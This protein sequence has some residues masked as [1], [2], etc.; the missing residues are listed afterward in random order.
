MSDNPPSSVCVNKNIVL[1]KFMAFTQG[2]FTTSSLLLLEVFRPDNVTL[3]QDAGID[4]TGCYPVF[5]ENGTLS[6]KFIL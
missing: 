6:Y 2:R 1:F 4:I 5:T 3:W